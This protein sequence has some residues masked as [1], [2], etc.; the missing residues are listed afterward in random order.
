MSS[1]D[2]KSWIRASEAKNNPVP[3]QE[4][5]GNKIREFLVARALFNRKNSKSKNLDYLTKHEWDIV[6][7]KVVAGGPCVD[8]AQPALGPDAVAE[9]CEGAGREAGG[10]AARRSRQQSIST[11]RPG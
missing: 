5:L 10:K 7:N 1:S 11:G 6:N 4:V 8:A 3:S 2:S 9:E